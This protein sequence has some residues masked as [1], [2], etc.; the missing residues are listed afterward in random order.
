MVQAFHVVSEQKRN[1]QR[2]FMAFS[3]FMGVGTFILSL[4][5]L[6]FFCQLQSIHR[7][8][9]LFNN[10]TSTYTQIQNNFT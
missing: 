10:F 9:Q 7:E 5:N 8:N 3:V 2:P 6:R 1:Q 4:V